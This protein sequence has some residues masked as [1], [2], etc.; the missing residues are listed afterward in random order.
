[1]PGRTKTRLIPALGAGG[2]AALHRRLVLRTLRLAD[3]L[4]RAKDVEL[5]IRFEGTDEAAMR[6]WLGDGPRYREQGEGDLGA[7]L[8][9][10]FEV[11]FREGSPATILIGTDCPG[12]TVDLVSTAYAKLSANPVVLGPAADGGYYLVGMRRP[13]PELFRGL[14]WG[15]ETVLAD[16]LDRLARAGLRPALLDRLHDIDRPEDLPFWHG[17]ADAEDADLRRVSV[18]IPALNE[19]GHIAETIATAR[20]GAPH[21]VVVVDGGSTDHTPELAHA[22]GATVLCSMPSRARQMNAGAAR[23]RG[24]VLLFLHADTRLPPDWLRVVSDTLQRP[25]VATGAFRFRIAEDFPGSRLAQ[26]T[27]NLRSRWLRRPYGDQAL[28]LR[29]ALFEELGG[30]ADLPIMEDYEFVGRVR[31]RGQVVTTTE[32]IVTSGRRWRRLGFVR[33]T[34]VNKLVI[35]AYRLGV[36]PQKLARIY[37]QGPQTTQES[38]NTG[39]LTMAPPRRAD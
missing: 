28:F 36:A 31:R 19:S 9:R 37:Q 8:A 1:M 22:A 14:A 39:S 12:L 25:G 10:A 5:E 20:H 18:I 15:G 26:W 33:T 13:I 29:R 2:A 27:T 11:S 4:G 16:S 24:S 21:E 32:A 6:H 7:R 34:L 38:V 23:A 3:A 30:F 17:L 35:A